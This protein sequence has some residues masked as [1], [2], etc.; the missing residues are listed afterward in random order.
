MA[1]E[2]KYPQITVELCGKDGNAFFILGE[3]KR[4]LRVHDIEPV[5]IE[6]FVTEA[7]S[8]DYDH[9]LATCMRWV[10]VH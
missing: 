8:G 9:L 7:T 10:N 2:I 6:Q 3:V 1:T 4:A 5:F